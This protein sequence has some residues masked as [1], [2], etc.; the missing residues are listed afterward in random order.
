MPLEGLVDVDKECA[1]LR[2]ELAGL[3]KQLAALEG[4]LANEGFVSRA[5]AHVV[6]AERVKQGEWTTR[7]DLL[8]ARVGALCGGR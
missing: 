3:E 1:K 5:P 4:R 7:R 2:T 6:E 8:R